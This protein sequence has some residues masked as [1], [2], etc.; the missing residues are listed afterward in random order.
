[1]LTSTNLEFSGGFLAEVI[2]T[3]KGEV[4]FRGLTDGDVD[5]ESEWNKQRKA[6]INGN[7]DILGALSLVL[8]TLILIPLLKYVLVV[9]WAN[10]DG[11]VYKSME[12]DSLYSYGFVLLRALGYTILFTSITSLQGI[13]LKHGILL[14]FVFYTQLGW[15]ALIMGLFSGSIPWLSTR[16]QSY[17]K[18]YAGSNIHKF[19]MPT[20]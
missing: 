8:C 5:T 3:I 18:S 19:D 4:F 6:H 15:V 13:Q 12:Q 17:S 14:G 10:D 11:E 1:M 9:L 2:Q 16:D 20:H 7:E